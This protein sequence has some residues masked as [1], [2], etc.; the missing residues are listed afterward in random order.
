MLKRAGP[1]VLILFVFFGAV[2]AADRLA[3]LAAERTIR[4]RAAASASIWLRFFSTELG[5]F[6]TVLKQARPTPRQEAVLAEARRFV[7]VFRFKLFDAAGHLRIL[8]DDIG[9]ASQ[10]SGNLARHNPV[11]AKVVRS[12]EIFTEVFDG[13]N[14]PDRPDRYAETYLP[15][16]QD[17]RKIGVV[18]VYVDVTE[19]FRAVHATFARFGVALSALVAVA[20]AG[21]ALIALCLARRLRRRNRAL[22][23]ARDQAKAAEKAKSAFLANMSHEIRSPMNGVM[24][25]AELLAE[26]PLTPE[27]RSFVRTISSSAEALLT[28][29]NDI[30]DFSKA[31]AGKMRLSPAPFDLHTLVHDVAALMAPVAEAKGLEICVDGA[32]E[33]HAW[34]IGDAARLRQCLLNLVSN[35]V[36]FTE[37][38]HVLISLSETPEGGL[39]IAV[40]DTGIGIPADRL[41][42]IFVA[43][44]QVDGGDTRRFDGTGLGLA[45]TRKLVDL[46]E[47][48]ITAASTEGRGSSFAMRLPLE[49]TVA[50]GSQAPTAP[51][52]LRGLRALVVDDL[53]INRRI[54]AARLERWGVAV[55]LAS[56]ADAAERV[57]RDAAAAGRRFDFA[58][59]DFH[60]PRRTGLDLL[61]ALRE[62]PSTSAMPAIIL[63]S[64]DLSARKE[65]LGAKGVSGVLTKPAR[66]EVLERAIAEALGPG[67]PAAPAQAAPRPDRSRF[68]GRR[69]LL[70]EDNDVNR[71]VVIGMLAPLGLAIEEACDGLAAVEAYRA[72]PPDAVLMDLSMPTM[73]GIEATR[74]IRAFEAAQGLPRRPVIA[75]TANVMQEDRA[76]CLAAGMTSFLGKPVKK[77]DLIAAL[78]AEIVAAAA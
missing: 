77:A 65:A 74:A 35:A 7:D 59:L 75:L 8:S 15:I 38:G 14:R 78:E 22:A 27:Q 55:D 53:E 60:M 29:I 24:G 40:R 9:S 69:L 57:V 54:L 31:E 72:S 39:S 34:W 64:S 48:A 67:V 76:R 12:G 25:T 51:R 19:D 49:K 66:A 73:N 62:D 10:A 36:K 32:A 50:A 13:S 44:E 71:M 45:I 37:S 58:V 1:A 23:A 5:G 33:T 68:Q 20:M 63:S 46:M 18:E 4:D 16:L 6:E 26:T 30:L 3:T 21:P 56:S 28:V 17:G 47:G 70:A 11:A 61:R 41:D 2:F 43:F 52:D 42:L